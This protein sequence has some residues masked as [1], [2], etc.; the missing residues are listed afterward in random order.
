MRLS[1]VVSAQGT[2]IVYVGR[3][4]TPRKL[5]EMV[6]MRLVLVTGR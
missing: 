2:D 6:V 1:V 3:R 5:I 4:K